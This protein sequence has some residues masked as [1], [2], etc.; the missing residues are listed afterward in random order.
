MKGFNIYMMYNK[1]AAFSVF[2]FARIW[3]MFFR[4]DSLP[5]MSPLESIFTNCKIIRNSTFNFIALIPN[6]KCLKEWCLYRNAP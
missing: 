4:A 2:I 1:S 3:Q 5:E 6:Y